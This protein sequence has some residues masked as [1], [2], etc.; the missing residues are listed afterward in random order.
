LIVQRK[1]EMRF[2]HPLLLAILG[3]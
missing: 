3:D 2:I 1:Y